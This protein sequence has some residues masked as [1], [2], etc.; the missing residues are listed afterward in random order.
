MVANA[1]YCYCT[2]DP[3][4]ENYKCSVNNNKAVPIQAQDKQGPPYKPYGQSIAPGALGPVPIADVDL[5]DIY[6]VIVVSRKN[7]YYSI[8]TKDSI[9]NKTFYVVTRN[10][11][12][13]DLP[14][15]HE[16][17]KC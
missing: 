10:Y 13:I 8:W 16:K 17:L 2:G 4:S 15:I 11:D 12:G 6:H 9:A 7:E 5:H 3:E 14:Y 1:T